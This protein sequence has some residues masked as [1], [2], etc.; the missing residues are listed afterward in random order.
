VKV[1]PLH[2]QEKHQD[3]TELNNLNPISISNIEEKSLSSY[4]QVINSHHYL[5][6]P[7]I[8]HV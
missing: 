7:T 8:S 4:E 2:F 1:V 3:E 5:L 6:E